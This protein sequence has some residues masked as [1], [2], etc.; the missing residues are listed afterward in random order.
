M[1]GEATDF[2]NPSQWSIP[3]DTVS[4]LDCG[5]DIRIA[6]NRIFAATEPDE[7][8][9]SLAMG[10]CPAIADRIRDLVEMA[11]DDALNGT[12]VVLASLRELALF[13]LSQRALPNPE[14]GLSPSGILLA[15][16]ASDERGVLAIKFLLNGMLQFAGVSA[17]QS[18]GCG[19]RVHSELPNDRAMDAV[20]AFIP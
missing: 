18:A 16:W 10:G 9:A 19:F 15:E 2:Q 4:T 13:A 5:D 3:K 11:R 14:I 20:R 7:I 8:A 17:R 12:D 1:L 6:I